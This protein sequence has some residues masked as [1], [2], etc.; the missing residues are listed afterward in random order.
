MTGSSGK[1][2]AVSRY[3]KIEPPLPPSSRRDLLALAALG[4][5]GVPRLAGGRGRRAN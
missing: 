1:G 5:A 4:L 2:N 3:A